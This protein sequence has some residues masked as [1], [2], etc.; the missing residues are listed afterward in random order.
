MKIIVIVLYMNKMSKL[1]I[2]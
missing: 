1:L 2:L